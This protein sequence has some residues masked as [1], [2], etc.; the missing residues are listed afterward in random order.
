MR[1]YIAIN[2]TKDKKAAT[3]ALKRNKT[4]AERVF[5]AF[6]SYLRSQIQKHEDYEQ[7]NTYR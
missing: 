1:I 3:L 4:N 7:D 6:Y 2:L 5:L